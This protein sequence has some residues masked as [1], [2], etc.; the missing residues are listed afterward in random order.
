[1]SAKFNL[2]YQDLKID[3]SNWIDD[4]DERNELNL[5]ARLMEDFYPFEISINLSPKNLFDSQKIIFHV[6]DSDAVVMINFQ[7]RF[8]N[9]TIDVDFF[10]SSR[11]KFDL[12]S[13]RNWLSEGG[14]F[15]A[16]ALHFT[17]GS[18]ACNERYFISP[19]FS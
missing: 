4:Q 13:Y 12:E 3:I 15:D 17:F 18:F 8:I 19:I 9:L 7:E 10:V 5:V 11:N 16:P 1:M 6:S 14:V 2:Q